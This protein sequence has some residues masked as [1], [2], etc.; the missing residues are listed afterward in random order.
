MRKL[1]KGAGLGLREV[2]RKMG[3]SAA[4]ISDLELGR[5]GWSGDLIRAYQKA[6]K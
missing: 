5:R 2:A 1:R 4:Y 6:I 3:L